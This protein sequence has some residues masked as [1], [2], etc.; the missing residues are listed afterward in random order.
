MAASN[1]FIKRS[2]P[3]ETARLLIS[4]GASEV[5]IDDITV[6]KYFNGPRSMFNFLQQLMYPSYR[7]IPPQ[8]RFDIAARICESRWHNI[9]A[10]LST[11]LRVE[12]DF[13]KELLTL[14]NRWGHTLLH[15]LVIGFVQT[16]II[17]SRPDRHWDDSLSSEELE[18]M[19]T[20]K[21]NSISW[22]PLIRKVIAAGADL[23]ALDVWARTPLCSLIP[24]YSVFGPEHVHLLKCWLEDLLYAG[25]DLVQYGA[26]ESM[27][28]QK[29]WPM[30]Q[31]PTLDCACSRY[32]SS[33]S[34]PRTCIRTNKCR[35]PTR[36]INL[37]YG[38]R[39]EDWIF[40]L[41]EPT[42]E[43][44]GE[45]WS[46]IE[47]PSENEAEECLME[48]QMPGSWNEAEGSSSDEE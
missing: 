4:K 47:D 13:D 29:R 6:V 3:W 23:N 34:W 30:N 40:W 10:I 17:R 9:P 27:A 33:C 28:L 39:P 19:T 5:L 7:E 16:N 45:F 37:H 42:D 46:M 41:S 26:L 38:P 48:F 14:N 32:N 24:R 11:L 43:F 8:T 12:A 25:I 21:T 22:R 18:Y 20:T 31:E 15:L 2:Q 36:L 44:T 1:T 35:S